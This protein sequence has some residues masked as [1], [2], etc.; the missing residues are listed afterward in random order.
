MKSKPKRVTQK[1]VD[2]VRDGD[3]LGELEVE[4]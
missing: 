1:R 4:H 2:K 3:Q